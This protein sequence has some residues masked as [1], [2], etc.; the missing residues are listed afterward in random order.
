MSELVD[1]VERALADPDAP[2]YGSDLVPLVAEVLEELAAA[3]AECDVAR[4][5][6][7]VLRAAWF[8][9]QL[10]SNAH[11]REWED[12]EHE[13]RRHENNAALLATYDA[14]TEG[15][16]RGESWPV[17]PTCAA[18]MAAAAAGGDA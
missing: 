5:A 8:A 14:Q 17:F 9:A 18:D 12:E 7:R 2:W 13:Q 3:R 10:R 4:R 15:I 11:E 16:L 6:F 1:R